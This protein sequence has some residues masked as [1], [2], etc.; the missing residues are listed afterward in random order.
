M[1]SKILKCACVAIEGKLGDAIYNASKIVEAINIAIKDNIDILCFS[2]MALTGYSCGDILYNRYLY[3]HIEKAIGT[4]ENTTIGE[5]IF[6]VFGAPVVVDNK[7]C[8]CAIVV[9]NGSV[10]GA[11]PKITI[12]DNNGICESRWFDVPGKNDKNTIV[13]SNHNVPFLPN[14]I[15]CDADKNIKIGVVLGLDFD[16]PISMGSVLAYH[17]V[18]IILNPSVT[19]ETVCRYEEV[20]DM[21]KV[22]SRKYRSAYMYVSSGHTESTTD[23]VFS[24]YLSIYQNGICLSQTLD[25]FD[26]TK[27][28]SAYIDVE[29]IQQQKLKYHVLK[30]CCYLYDVDDCNEVEINLKPCIQE[31]LKVEKEPFLAGLPIDIICSRIINIQCRAIIQK[32]RYSNR[33]KVIIGI[34]GGLDSTIALLA[35][36]NAFKTGNIPLSNIIGV[37]MPGPGT[38]ARTYK[39]SCMLMKV[40]GVTSIN[41]DIKDTVMAHLKNINHPE[42]LFDITYEQTQSRERTKILMDLANQKNGIVIGTG[43]MS[44]I[45]L[46]WMSYS[47]DQISMYGLNCGIP[48]SVIKHLMEYYISKA[49]NELKEVLQDIINTPVSPELLPLDVNGRQ[50]QETENLIG[51]YMIQDFYLYYFVKFGYCVEKILKLAYGA[52]G[53]Q[54]SYCQLKTWMEIFVKRFYTRQFKRT[55]FPDGCQVFDVSLSPRNG[56]KMPSDVFNDSLLE[57]VRTYKDE[58]LGN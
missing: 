58:K 17:N 20:K 33:N 38:T 43:D 32:M 22:A 27:F 13:L 47:G 53:E 54:Y 19:F 51:P 21:V 5:K 40:L 35:C 9:H 3:N 42:M 52:F 4:I 45:A 2:E 34:S 16:S 30:S 28:I 26:D 31:E 25:S 41:I 39:N 36:Y 11:V 10:I 48:K 18:D 1:R 44:E 29:Q 49:C 37:T 14:L 50:K 12:N 55:C 57:E 7:I 8:N 46:G 6:V 24:N 15:F 56:W 23:N